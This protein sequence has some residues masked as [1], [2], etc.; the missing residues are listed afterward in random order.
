LVLILSQ[1]DLMQIV[2]WQWRW[3]AW[4]LILTAPTLAYFSHPKMKLTGSARST[5]D[6]QRTAQLYNPDIRTLQVN[7]SPKFIKLTKFNT[8]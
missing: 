4:T 2:L 3:S 7:L 8:E 5:A 1:N 6:V